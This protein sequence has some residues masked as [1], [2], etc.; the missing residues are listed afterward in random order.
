MHYVYPLCV[1]RKIKLALFSTFMKVCSDMIYFPCSKY[2]LLPT[3]KV[4][5][6]YFLEFQMQAR[7]NYNYMYYFNLKA[8]I[9]TATDDSLTFFI[10]FFL[11]Y[12]FF[13]GGG[14]RS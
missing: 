8:P 9:T 2:P 12:F 14:E 10:L 11:F 7:I 5:K 6:S 3:R 13:L 1:T 4:E